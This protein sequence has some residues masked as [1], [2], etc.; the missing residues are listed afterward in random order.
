MNLDNA[1]RGE[2]LQLAVVYTSGMAS[3]DEFTR[4]EALLD[5]SEEA[6]AFYIDSLGT[7]ANLYWYH[8]QG[9]EEVEGHPAG[10]GWNP[11]DAV[12]GEESLAT[13]PI[14]THQSA[15]LPRDHSASS[16]RPVVSPLGFLTTTLHATIGSFPEGM[17][18]AYLIAT[19]VTGLGLLIGSLIHVSEPEQIAH[20]SVPVIAGPK[21]EYVGRITEMVDCHWENEAGGGGRGTGAE[22]HGS[23]VAFGN[24]F[25]LASGLME[26]TYNAGAK[27][28][29]QG[30]VTYEAEANGGYLAIGKLTGKLEKQVVSGQWPVVSKSQI[31]NPKSEISNPQ[32]PIPNPF[33][34][35]TPTATVTDLGTEFGIEV[36][37]SGSSEVHVIKG[38]VD[39][40]ASEGAGRVRLCAGGRECAVR[41]ET[42]SR[43]IVVLSAASERFVRA[44]PGSPRTVGSPLVWRELA[45]IVKGAVS[46]CTGESFP[47]DGTVRQYA[48]YA[49]YPY[50]HSRSVTPLIF[51]RDDTGRFILTGIGESIT[52]TQMGAHRVPFRLVAGSAEVK[53]GV[54]TFGHFDGLVVAAGPRDARI[55]SP[56]AGVIPMQPGGGPWHFGRYRGSEIK[57]G[58]VFAFGAVDG[59]GSTRRPYRFQDDTPLLLHFDS[60]SDV[61]TLMRVGN[62]TRVAGRFGDAV[63]FSGKDAVYVTQSGFTDDAGALECWVRLTAG[64]NDGGTILRLD[65]SSPVWSYHLL[66]RTST[67]RVQYQVF[68]GT[69]G[70][71]VVSAA[72]STGVW[73]HL[74]ATHD[75]ADGGK[76]ELFIDGVSQGT[77]G[78]AATTCGNQ[79]LNV[80][81][82]PYGDTV[83]NGLQGGV[84]E[85][86]LSNVVRYT[87]DFTPAAQP[88]TLDADSRTYSEQM[89]VEPKA[90]LL[91]HA[92]REGGG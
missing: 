86:R 50:E 40:V 16:V 44:L 78:Y 14:S 22:N 3:H 35:H 59:D 70:P 18:L 73:H 36:E 85:V 55:V 20:T 26:I 80:G 28:I 52:T 2:L 46:I 81:G 41:I 91:Q 19:V 90:T 49:R 10:G 63:K 56:N 68:D 8:R 24:K 69:Q 88:Y 74:L 75:V 66:Y 13:F 29:L 25:A 53:A 34:I 42:G 23:L 5:A 72:L 38:A 37:K 71:T 43:K 67:D 61:P 27:V 87:S 89:T 17:P 12:G 6:R 33:V 1:L 77:A 51:A 9:E 79:P 92:P 4:L 65:G 54:H 48:F 31:P 58:S 32:S 76:I 62:P 15:T 47:V 39:V 64:S 7:H 82:L 83:H 11:T 21:A 84:D 30:P 60:V 57:L 45:D